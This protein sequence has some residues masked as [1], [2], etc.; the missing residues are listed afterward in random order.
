MKNTSFH[1]FIVFFF[2]IAIS[3]KKKKDKEL[4]I[5]FSDDFPECHAKNV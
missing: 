4:V 5:T 2:E 1:I 3:K